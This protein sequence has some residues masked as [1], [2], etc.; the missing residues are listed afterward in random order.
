MIKYKTKVVIAAMNINIET[1]KVHVAIKKRAKMAIHLNK[2]VQIKI[3]I[4][5][6]D[7]A[8]I[9]VLSKYFNYSNLL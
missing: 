8:F 3:N 9:I 7:K 4:L 1:F 2:K 6:F 5:L